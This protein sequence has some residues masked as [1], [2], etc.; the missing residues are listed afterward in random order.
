[1]KPPLS[2]CSRGKVLRIPR[3]TV[4]L[5]HHCS[6]PSSRSSEGR[7]LYCCC[8]IMASFFLASL[9]SLSFRSIS[10]WAA[11]IYDTTQPVSSLSTYELQS[12]IQS[13]E[14]LVNISFVSVADLPVFIEL[15]HLN[16]IKTRNAASHKI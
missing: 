16:Y 12:H 5:V 4:A 3:I 14:N 1:M 10:S 7:N 13:V 15:T 2:K 8:L 9:S 11:M 6:W